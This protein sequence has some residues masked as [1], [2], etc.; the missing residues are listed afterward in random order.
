MAA[1]E[2]AVPV[3]RPHRFGALR[4]R[5]RAR[6]A[7]WVR[8]RQGA[9]QLPVALERRRLYILPTRGGLAFAALVF[10]MLL[11]GLNYGNSLALFLTF[12]LTAFGLV[13]MQQCHRNLLGA[14]VIAAEA[15]AVFAARPDKVLVTL[16]N[17]AD[18][19]RLGLEAALEELPRARADLSA[20]ARAR[21]AVVLP[22]Q[23]RG[24][25]RIS[26][27]RIATAHPFA[28]FRAW[29]WVHTPL[30]LIVYPGPAGALPM[31]LQG[32]PPGGTRPRTGAGLDEWVGLRAFRDG[33]SPRQVDWKAYA[34]EAPLLVKEYQS[35]GSELRV[36]DFA[37]VPLAGTEARLA[38]LARWVVDA[39][40][41]GERY[42]LRLPGAPPVGA[43]RGPQHRHR[44]LALLA[45][46]GTDA[47]GGAPP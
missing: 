19:P 10:V 14:V 4:T 43:D 38:Q 30:E 22:P 24:V 27:V 2:A 15:P 42:A 18:T 41:R 6:V 8:H 17:P 11:A 29:T 13:V 37:R 46:F 28:L 16:D 23:R 9:D 1:R 7:A 40:A 26:R 31:P 20:H 12:L 39:E 33:D 35:L 45:R 34:R 25:L 21:L 44:C 5:L 32:A 3:S 36:F 47:S